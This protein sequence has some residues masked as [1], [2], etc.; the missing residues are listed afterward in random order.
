MI[1]T[2]LEQFTAAE[3]SY[4]WLNGIPTNKTYIIDI[5]GVIASIV[6]SNDYAL[7]EPLHE[8]IR[9]VNRLHDAGNTNRF[10]YSSRHSN[11]NKYGPILLKNKCKIG[12]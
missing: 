6:A 3:K 8:N 9:R 10:I 2:R 1:L 5:D 12:E 11:G 7:A 4:H